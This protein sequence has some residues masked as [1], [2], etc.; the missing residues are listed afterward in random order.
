MM[1]K[2]KCT[3][4][5]GLRS[6]E[7]VAT[8]V[9]LNGRQHFVRVENDFLW[10]QGGTTFLPVGII[11]EDPRTHYFLIELP[12]EAETGAN[13]LWVKTEDLIQSH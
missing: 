13:R 5:K 10:N 6:S 1:A 4:S 7:R 2:L 11:H 3:V 8:I 12:Q 9:D